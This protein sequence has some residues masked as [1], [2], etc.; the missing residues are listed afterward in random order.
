MKYIKSYETKLFLCYEYNIYKEKS[1]EGD[2]TSVQN[3]ITYN[4]ESKKKYRKI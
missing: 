1:K 4:F 2:I 3:S